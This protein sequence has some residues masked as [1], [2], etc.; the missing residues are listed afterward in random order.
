MYIE[1]EATFPNINLDQARQKL[2]AA[3]ASLLRPEFLMRRTVFNLPPSQAIPGGWLRVRD[4]GDKTTLS[5]KVIDGQKIENQKEACLIIDNYQT[6]C[7]LLVRLGAQ[8]KAYQESRR[9]IWQLDKVEICLDQWP[10]L[11][12]FL[13]IEGQS[14]EEVKAAAKKIGLDY[15]EALFCSVDELYHRQYG[16]DVD[17][18][19]NHT[20]RLDFS[21]PN[22]FL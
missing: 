13:E 19:N 11:E 8:P 21:G 7:E 2:T 16:V 14:E 15:K 6:G 3:G 18:V 17:R 20:S 9:E 5:L 1:Y 10:Y 22:P 4:E 12:P